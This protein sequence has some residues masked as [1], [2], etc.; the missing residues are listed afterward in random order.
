MIRLPLAALL[1]M[2]AAPLWAQSALCAGTGTDGQ[3]IGGTEAASDVTTMEDYAEQMA[4]VLGGNVYAGLFTVS[5][6]TE[7]RI[8]AQGR[9]NG[10]PV[11][12]LYDASGAEVAS[13][14]DSGGNAAARAELELEPGQYCAVVRS[15][16][17]SPMTAFVRIAR[18]EAEPLTTGADSVPDQSSEPAPG[19][20]DGAVELGAFTG[21]PLTHV[22]A[23][24]DAPWLAFDL[25]QAAAL[26]ITASNTEADPTLRVETEDGEV[27]GENDDYDG[28]NSR[29][30]LTAEQAPGRY[31][32]ALGAL[33]D[34][35]Q[36]VTVEI[37]AYDPAAAVAA[38]YARG[39]AAPPMDGSYAMTDLGALQT[40][41]SR[42]VQATDAT[43][44]FSIDVPQDGMILAEALSIGPN[45]DPWLVIFDAR[46]REVAQ[47][48]DTASGTDALIATRID[49]GPHM[50]GVKQVA[51]GT[52]FVRLLLE[53]YVPAE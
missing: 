32:L 7:T 11:M 39:E 34:G 23:P 2:T 47:N 41:V 53:R 24:Q 44:W 52:G 43:T 26:T 20:C 9:G 3:W 21:A 12:T 10:D 29:V 49:A 1:S 18:T 37:S 35:S 14:D 38:L 33:S 6:P 45:G 25:T 13:D 42:D 27:L 31:C 50:I 30:D 40:R 16:D 15:F 48:D 5:A 46:G 28:L 8:E 22:A 4:L 17:D 51:G 36:P 19:D